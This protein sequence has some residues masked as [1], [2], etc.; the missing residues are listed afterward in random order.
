MRNA[1]TCLAI[2]RTRGERRLPRCRAL[3]FDARVQPCVEILRRFDR[4]EIAEQEQRAPDLRVVRGT[5]LTLEEVALHRDHFLTGKKIVDER[6]VLASKPTTI[7]RR[8]D[9]HET[10]RVTVPAPEGRVPGY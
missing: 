5:P 6:D 8:Q 7:H 9:P 3:R 10:I 2:I 1:E 4:R